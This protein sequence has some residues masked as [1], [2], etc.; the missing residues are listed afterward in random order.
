VGVLEIKGMILKSDDFLDKIEELVDQRGVEALVV[1]IESPGGT[2][3]PTQEVYRE[4]M[5]LR[6][7]GVPVVA[8]FGD[9][10]ASG[11]YYIGAAADTI[12]S[13]PGTLTGSIGVIMEYLNFEGVL[14]KVDVKA[15][16]IKSGLFK[17]I[18]NPTRDMTKKE[19]ALMNELVANLYGQFLADIAKGRGMTEED[20]QP[21]AD[22]RV[23]T[24]AMALDYKL[25]DKLGN[26]KDAI[27]EAARLAGIE[28]EPDVVYPRKPPMTFLEM[29][30]QSG[31]EGVHN[32]WMN[33]RA[34]QM[35]P[36]FYFLD[37]AFAPSALP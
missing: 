2:I 12:Y 25:V 27:E 7:N 23:L 29:L 9:V 13:N 36:S 16:V 33:M 22:G 21:Y 24:G 35:L 1:R 11:G 15:V 32:A 20:I 8:S 14:K 31:M 30:A 6:E 10:A 28:G 34:K 37:A 4:L 5:R 3:G 19:R 18:G 17:D 26:L